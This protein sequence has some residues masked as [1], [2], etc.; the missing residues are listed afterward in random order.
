MLLI[1]PTLLDALVFFI[2]T[3]MARLGSGTGFISNELVM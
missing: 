2:H 3:R 1:S